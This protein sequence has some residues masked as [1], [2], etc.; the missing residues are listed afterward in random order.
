M[1]ALFLDAYFY[2][3]KTAYSHLENDLIDGLI[4]RDVEICVLCPTPTRNVDK[5]VFYK[6]EERLKDGKLLVKRFWAPKERR[7]KFFRALRY[8]WCNL[9]QYNIAKKYKNIDFVFSVSTPPTQG[10]LGAKV[11]NRLS[12]KQNKYIPFIYNLQDIFPD[13]LVNTGITRRGSL[14]WKV[15][16][17]IEKKTYNSADRII[18][19]NESFKSN[20]IKKGVPE[21][22]ISVIY[23][24]V[25]IA[26]LK[27]ISKD[28]N[29]L[30]FELG[31]NQNKF[32]VVYAGNFGK[33]QGVETLID[34]AKRLEYK[35]EIEF[36][37][38]GGGSEFVSIKEKVEKNGI[39][40]VKIFP[41]LS[42]ERASEVYSLGDV[43]LILCKKGVGESG[44]PSKTWTIMACGVPIIASYD[45]DSELEQI[46]KKFDLG[47]VVEP[48]NSDKLAEAIVNFCDNKK[49]RELPTSNGSVFLKEN[50]SKETCVKKYCEEIFSLF[51]DKLI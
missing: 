28:E 1:R 9:R 4:D 45:K 29:P 10:L 44:M 34:A 30:Y 37:L 41:L 13:S 8:L 12:R 5:N 11:S 42:F 20:I 48:E 25:D 31:I 23:N 19:I 17:K 16:C 2:P 24:W 26:K 39:D 33:S 18:V 7:S 32:N 21:N 15:G 40:N 38:F 6:K 14:L 51:E 36:I 50:A 35:S 27:H 22:K 46:I 47:V 49:S 43:A 3:E